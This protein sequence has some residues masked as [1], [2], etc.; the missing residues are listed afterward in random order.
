MFVWISLCEKKSN[1][2]IQAKIPISLKASP[3]ALEWTQW[4]T[5]HKKKFYIINYQR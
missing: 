4:K 5:E 2:Q 3:Q 1:F